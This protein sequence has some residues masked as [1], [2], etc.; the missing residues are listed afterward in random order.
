MNKLSVVVS[1]LI[2]MMIL[3]G[4]MASARPETKAVHSGGKSPSSVTVITNR[5]VAGINA[6]ASDGVD[7]WDTAAPPPPPIN[8]LYDYFLLDSGSALSN[9]SADIRK[10]EP[11]LAMKAKE[12]KLR[13]ITDQLSTQVTLN[14]PFA[15][16]LPSGF[17]PVL[18]DLAMGVYQN[19]RSNPN[20]SYA[21]P[22]S[23]TVSSFK[24]LIGDSTN[25][26]VTVT[27]PVGG[28][29][30]VVGIPV[31]VTWGS[32]DGSGILNHDVYYSVGGVWTHI[33]SLG[34]SVQSTVWTLPAGVNTARIVVVA[35]DSVLNT[36]V[37]SSGTLSIGHTITAS[38]GPNGSISPSGAVFV[39]DGSDQ[40]F[41]IT[42]NSLF[43]IDS[44]LVD[45]LAAP[46]GNYTFSHVTA[47]HIIRVVFAN[48]AHTISASAGP[49]GAIAPSGSVTVNDGANQ[50]FTFTPNAGYHI[51]SIVVD[52]AY[53]GNTSP[54]QFSS[55]TANHT[56]SVKFAINTY[57]ITSSVIGG[58][59]TIAPL[60]VTTVNY[61]QNQSYTMMPATGYHIDSIF[62]NGVYAGKTTPYVFTNVQANYT[63]SVKFA[64]NTYTITATVI[65]GIGTINPP[66]STTVTYGANQ[67]YTITPS[68]GYHIDTLIVDGSYAG[69][70]SP[71]IFLNDT[72]NHTISVKFAINT[73]A[74][75]IN[76]SGSGSVSRLPNQSLYNYG[77]SVLLT[78]TPADYT[79]LFTGWTG[80][81][82]STSNPIII[83]TDSA[84]NVTA[85]FV[86]DSS[87]LTS[88]RTFTMDSIVYDRD[89]FGKLERMV[90]LKPLFAEFTISLQNRFDNISG[91][92]VEFGSSVDSIHFILSVVPSAAKIS[93][94]GRYKRW[95][96]LF[97][98][99]LHAGDSVFIHGY[100]A[101][102]NGQ[103]VADYNW[104]H[105]GTRFGPLLRDARVSNILHMPMPNRINALATAY[106]QGGFWRTKGLLVGYT[107]YDSAKAYGWLLMPNYREV[108]ETLHDRTGIQNG[109]PRN[110]D[111]FRNT[112]R[113]LVKQQSHL[114]PS[115]YNN[116]LLGDI[117]A[118]NINIAASMLSITPHGF[119]EL[120]YNDGSANPLNG[121]MV[122]QIDSLADSMMMARESHA[123]F[124]SRSCFDSTYGYVN[125]DTTIAR[126]NAAFEG[127]IDTISFITGLKFKGTRTLSAVPYLKK[128]PSG[129]IPDVIEPG[130][131][132]V[133]MLP[134]HF[135]VY[136]NYP[137]P[138]NPVT[139]IRFDVPVDATLT[140]KVYNILGQEV[141][142]LLRNELLTAGAKS[143]EFNAGNLAS[144]IYFYRVTAQSIGDPGTVS[145]KFESVRKM[146]LLK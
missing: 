121:L 73:F 142:V 15:E 46:K 129:I 86:R 62:V 113:P 92:H 27:Y 141:A 43:Q 119:G 7:S 18:Y 34:G 64:I 135:E 75:T 35:R 65:G 51:D 116:K 102:T 130:Q 61:G 1:Y 39:S 122:R 52:G 44:V 30:L 110:F 54:Y 55:V 10:D 20:Y 97:S 36:G 143:A 6:A 139:R 31:T 67:T 103:K 124:R 22:A 21:S 101:A 17:N 3:S 33:A 145:T 74:V 115:R 99:P 66:G 127:K 117:I 94:D 126:I 13:A 58:N 57:S 85:N 118:L 95:D 123:R 88:Y 28:E 144:G 47:N 5:V 50:G 32:S 56:I 98:A 87:Y 16:S 120:V 11:T 9:Y 23:E 71:Y 112:L 49:N 60:G 108:L 137:N 89:N 77:T 40:V 105:F 29:Q 69:Y 81:V 96:F 100:A 19:L 106:Q 131:Y 76:V 12:W 41:T 84:M 42:P 132:D 63:I 14:L 78:A 2:G 104:T 8:Y 59:G 140:L 82:S 128:R 125:V 90:L 133:V 25:P 26:A 45:G 93:T 138:F 136:Q 4:A 80:S 24:I 109:T 111:Y 48:A 114:E 91:I 38:A 68:T 146:L 53:W 107:C 134:Q 72:A 79:W 37:D 70:S 83:V